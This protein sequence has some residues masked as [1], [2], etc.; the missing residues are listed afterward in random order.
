MDA[1]QVSR[2]GHQRADD[3]G[4]VILRRLERE[5]DRRLGG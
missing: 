2:F 4:H 3:A 1:F 5:K